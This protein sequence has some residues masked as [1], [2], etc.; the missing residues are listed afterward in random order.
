[1]TH[2]V[3][4]MPRPTV[5][6]ELGHTAWAAYAAGAWAFVFAAISFYWAA[7]GTIG[8][9]TLGRTIEQLALAR[10]PMMVTIGGWGA[11]IAKAIAGLLALALVRPWGRLIPRSIVRTAAWSAGTLL[12][13]YGGANLFQHGLMAAGVIQIPKGL[14]SSALPWHLLFWDPFWLLGGSLFIRAAWYDSRTARPR[15]AR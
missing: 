6:R 8:L 11:G 12:V 4:T 14:G 7:G 10:D 5:T 1:M 13:L 2:E 15:Q 3:E 9:A